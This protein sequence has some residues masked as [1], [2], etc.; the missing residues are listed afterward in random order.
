M[1]SQWDRRIF[2]MSLY[3][4]PLVWILFGIASILKFNLH[5]LLVVV[6]AILMSMAN[7]L[8]YL[9]CEKDQRSQ[10]QTFA[11]QY[12]FRNVVKASTGL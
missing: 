10:L 1:T 11:K 4:A 8:G 6:V 12:L 3:I 5:W 2:W 7:V 9:R